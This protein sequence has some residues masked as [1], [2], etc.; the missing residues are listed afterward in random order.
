MLKTSR[1]TLGTRFFL[2]ERIE[3]EI[4]DTLEGTVKVIRSNFTIHGHTTGLPWPSHRFYIKRFQ[5][6]IGTRQDELEVAFEGK[7]TIGKHI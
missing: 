5:V 4:I 7:L 6:S 3:I 2:G 1:I